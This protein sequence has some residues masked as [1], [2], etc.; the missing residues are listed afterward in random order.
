MMPKCNARIVLT[1]LSETYCQREQGHAGPHSIQAHP[2]VVPPPKVVGT[3]LTPFI[4]K[5]GS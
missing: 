4:T 1:P 2:I 5:A 3:P